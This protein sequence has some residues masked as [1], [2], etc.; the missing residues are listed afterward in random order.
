MSSAIGRRQRRQRL[1]R[2]LGGALVGYGVVGLILLAVVGSALAAPIA[3]LDELTDSVEAQRTAALESLRAASETVDQTGTAVDGM[4]ASLAQAKAA[5]DRA[6]TIALGVAESMSQLGNAM[7]VTIFGVQPLVGLQQG[8]VS[9]SVQLTLLAD[10]LLG[11]GE[12][13]DANRADAVL[14]GESLDALGESL[15][16]LRTAVSDTPQLD[17]A[18]ASID[19]M[20]LGVL[21]LLAWLAV[22]AAGAVVAGAGCWYLARD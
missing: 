13:L 5:T 20:R 18:T 19:A 1:L 12:A 22:L 10:D 21:A 17:S 11:I 6:S 9:A 4:D 16:A 7:T 2:L 14:V 3:Q 8:F 15:D